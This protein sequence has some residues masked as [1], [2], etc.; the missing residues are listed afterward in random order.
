MKIHLHY[1]Y[2]YQEN[3]N[4]SCISADAVGRVS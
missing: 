4:E 2:P 1:S 3:E